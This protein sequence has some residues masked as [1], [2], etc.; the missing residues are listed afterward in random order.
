MTVRSPESA[1][2]D[3][4]A[5]GVMRIDAEGVIALVNPT[6]ETLLGRSASSLVGRPLASVMPADASFI[7]VV[8]RVSRQGGRVSARAVRIEG[9]QLGPA[10][11]DVFAAPTG[12]EGG[13]TVALVPVRA[14]P[15]APGAEVGA[16]VEVARMLG[17][18]VKNP[19]AGITGAAQLLAR[20]AR[21]DQQ[22][23]LA[24]IREEGARIVRIVDRFTAFETFFH[25][26]PRSTNVHEVLDSVIELARA[27]F[28]SSAD[29]D[30]RYDP[31]LPE[32]EA[33]PDHLHEACLNLVK[34]AVEAVPPGKPPR[35]QLSTRYRAGFRFAGRDLPR[36]RGALEI[37][38]GDNGPGLPDAVAGRAFEPFFTTKSGGAG[39]GLAIVSEIVSAHGG[40]AVLENGPAGAVARLL[41]PIHR[42]RKGATL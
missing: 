1:A 23:L 32:I 17:H 25:P 9:A 22:A 19:L 4:L 35:I 12:P 28:G 40:F 6:T 30:L 26:R 14:T 16:F 5:V 42:N 15:E 2:I 11:V 24:L 36:A 27:S 13:V 34:N 7:D 21:A 8:K 41:F 37:A 10:E 18:E 33:D 29:F 39:V 20:E 38:V 31:S 3:A